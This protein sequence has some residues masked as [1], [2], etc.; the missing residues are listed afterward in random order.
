MVFIGTVVAMFIASRNETDLAAQRFHEMF[1]ALLAVCAGLL[2]LFI[3][4]VKILHNKRAI[5][6][7][8]FTIIEGMAEKYIPS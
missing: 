2:I 1:P 6:K 8:N 4:G 5:K 7:G 3:R